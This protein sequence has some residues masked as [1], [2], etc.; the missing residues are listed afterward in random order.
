MLA[1]SLRSSLINL[2]SEIDPPGMPR[3][4]RPRF[5]SDGAID[6]QFVSHSYFSTYVRYVNGMESAF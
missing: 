4:H 3:H 1:P 6:W 5:A 2:I